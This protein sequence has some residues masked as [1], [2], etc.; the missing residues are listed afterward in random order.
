MV[1]ETL[2]AKSGWNLL[3]GG[4]GGAVKA[5]AITGFWH[6]KVYLVSDIGVIYTD[7]IKFTSASILSWPDFVKK[8][9]LR[10]QGSHPEHAFLTP[11]LGEPAGRSSSIACG[12]FLS[13]FPRFLFFFLF[14]FVFFENHPQLMK[15]TH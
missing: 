1:E 6:E 14:F 5:V 10:S 2:R 15:K 13:F 4:G 7:F 12:T 8:A 11:P 9:L 3:S